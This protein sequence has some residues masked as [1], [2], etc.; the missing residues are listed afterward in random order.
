MQEDGYTCLTQSTTSALCAGET[1]GLPHVHCSTGG[2][3][4]KPTSS[5]RQFCID[6]VYVWIF[7]FC[8][9]SVLNERIRGKLMERRFLLFIL[10]FK[11]N[12]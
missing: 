8:W 11:E 2:R 5:F 4:M 3:K 10:Y 1:C 9:R 6:D 7:I 12:V